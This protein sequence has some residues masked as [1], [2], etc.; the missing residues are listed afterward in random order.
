MPPSGS[1]EVARDDVPVRPQC[2]VFDD[3][4]DFPGMSDTLDHSRSDTEIFVHSRAFGGETP[5]E[6]SRDA[7]C[8]LS[9]DMVQKYTGLCVEAVRRERRLASSQAVTETSS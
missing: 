6:S 5:L 4:T 9:R 8:S 3:D 1:R 2:T 7:E